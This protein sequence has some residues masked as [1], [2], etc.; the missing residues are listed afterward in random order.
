MTENALLY[1]LLLITGKVLL[2]YIL[3][4]YLL[5]FIFIAV[6]DTVGNKGAFIN[7]TPDM[8]LDYVSFTAV[9]S[10]DVSMKQGEGRF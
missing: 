10:L 5:Y 9:V 7:I 2:F 4:T 3:F 8:K 1:S 6:S